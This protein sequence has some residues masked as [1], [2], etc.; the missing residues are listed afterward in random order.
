MILVILSLLLWLWDLG[1]LQNPGQMSQT[2][3]G[4]ISRSTW[5]CSWCAGGLV[6]SR[7]LNKRVCAEHL[8]QHLA[9]S[10]PSQFS[11]R[12]PLPSSSLP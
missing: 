9:H 10:E 7:M 2:P 11:E 1:W 6:V 8:T 5:Q 4:L 3:H 12:S